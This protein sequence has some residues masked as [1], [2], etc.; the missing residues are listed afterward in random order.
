MRVMAWGLRVWDAARSH[1]TSLVYDVYLC[2]ADWVG[3]GALLHGVGDDHAVVSVVGD[4]PPHPARWCRGCPSLPGL[5]LAVPPVFSSQHAMTSANVPLHAGGTTFV[6]GACDRL[7]P[8]ISSHLVGQGLAVSQ[9]T[10]AV[11]DHIASPSK[12]RPLV[13]SLHG[14]PGVGKSMVHLLTAQTLYSKHPSP[15]LACPGHDCAG[16]KVWAVAWNLFEG[17]VGNSLSS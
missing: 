17:T 8:Y 4:G 2:L 16:Y 10:D 3:D 13:L 1:L 12:S 9:L 11:C 15:A 14:P 7:E 5:Q 6:P